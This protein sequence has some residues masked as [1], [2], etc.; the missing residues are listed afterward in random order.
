MSFAGV[1]SEI[2]KKE[3]HE[4]QDCQLIIDEI[5]EECNCQDPCQKSGNLQPEKS[6]NHPFGEPVCGSDHVTYRDA[7]QL[8]NAACGKHANITQ[9]AEVPCG[10]IQLF[11]YSTLLAYVT[12]LFNFR[13]VK[14]L[15]F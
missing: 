1:C 14:T 7:C 8:R 2:E 11:N 4:V 13:G 12:N 10:N 3:C 9:I 15:Q 6:G 5:N